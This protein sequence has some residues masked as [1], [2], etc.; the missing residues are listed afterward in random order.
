MRL[1]HKRISDE[2]Q[3]LMNMQAVWTRLQLPPE[4]SLLEVRR[5]RVFIMAG[6]GLVLW[7]AENDDKAF[8]CAVEGLRPI[9]L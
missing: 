8:T 4:Y 3:M 5:D 9:T 1:W 6:L 2:D 7:L